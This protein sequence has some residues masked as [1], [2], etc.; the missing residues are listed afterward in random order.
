MQRA[1]ATIPLRAGGVTFLPPRYLGSNAY[2]IMKGTIRAKISPSRPARVCDSLRHDVGAGSGH[3]FKP[4]S[5]DKNLT[6]SPHGLPVPAGNT[7]AS[8]TPQVC[9]AYAAIDGSLHSEYNNVLAPYGPSAATV[10]VVPTTA[11]VP[12]A[13]AAGF[14]FGSFGSSTALFFPV[15][16]PSHAGRRSHESVTADPTIA[17]FSYFNVPGAAEVSGDA[18]P[19]GCNTDK[20]SGRGGEAG[21]FG[22]CMPNI[23]NPCAS[24]YGVALNAFAMSVR[25]NSPPVPPF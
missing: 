10:A 25:V 2:R 7:R 5:R 20:G 16:P 6:L 13:L 24:I 22:I 21:A 3:A 4:T 9:N 17:A 14:L 1:S 19:I 23:W 8:T 18:L 12:I 11:A 15:F